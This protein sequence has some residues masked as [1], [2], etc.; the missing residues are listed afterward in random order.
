MLPM[1]IQTSLD[2]VRM[3]G[4]GAPGFGSPSTVHNDGV[5]G[6]HA[7]QS[8]AECEDRTHVTSHGAKVEEKLSVSDT[9]DDSL[10]LSTLI[11]KRATTAISRLSLS[12]S[13]EDEVVPIAHR[14]QGPTDVPILCLPP[15][16]PGVRRMRDELLALLGPSSYLA[17]VCNVVADGR[18]LVAAVLLALGLIEHDHVTA[19][20]TPKDRA[21]RDCIDSQRRLLGDVMHTNWTEERWLS[22][23]PLDLRRTHVQHKD[24]SN[25]IIT[26]VL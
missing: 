20:G 16:P 24:G 4:I 3:D 15:A 12:Q 19:A 2:E 8:T 11:D 6:R 25:D 26:D 5:V 1:P 13:E 23:V 14:V 18:C 7:A 9:E 21:T 22:T 17:R 10:P